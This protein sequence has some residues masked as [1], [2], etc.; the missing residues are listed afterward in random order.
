M[1]M[2]PS[3]LL[4]TALPIPDDKPLCQKPPSP[5]MDMGRLDE[6][7]LKAAALDAP[8]PYPMVVAPRL[9]GGRIENRWQPMSQAMWCSP[10][11]SC[12]KVKAAKMGRSGQ[13]VQKPAGRGGTTFARLGLGAG[14]TV[15]LRW[16][17]T[18]C[19]FIK[20]LL[21]AGASATSCSRPGLY[22]LKKACR[23]SRITA[24]VYSPASGNTSL[25]AST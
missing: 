4:K 5:M 19:S 17:C 24:V 1:M 9:N 8:R 13:P 15:G 2:T 23:P 18:T 10:S 22:L 25:P 20:G 21:A 16:N 14:T 11:L 6:G 12:A 3:Y 7:T